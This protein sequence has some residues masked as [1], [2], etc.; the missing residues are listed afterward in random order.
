MHHS[1]KW[2]TY[3]AHRHLIGGECAGLVRADDGRTAQGLHR[4]QT[5]DDGVLLRHASGS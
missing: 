4:G 5:A 3:P 1:S 2:F